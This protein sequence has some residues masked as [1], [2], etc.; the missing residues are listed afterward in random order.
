MKN[1]REKEHITV[2]K[3]G[4]IY[5]TESG[6]AIADMI[7]ERHK[8]LTAW[9]TQLGVDEAIAAEDACR[10]EHISKE[11]LKRS[12]IILNHTADHKNIC[13][14]LYFCSPQM[15][16]VYVIAYISLSDHKFPLPLKRFS[17]FPSGDQNNVTLCFFQI[18]STKHHTVFI[19]VPSI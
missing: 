5:L 6:K 14:E 15:F 10:M 17:T 11:S 19:P 1:L 12:K 4:F 9:L 7:Y 2:T 3:E 16:L 8:L 13:E 18:V